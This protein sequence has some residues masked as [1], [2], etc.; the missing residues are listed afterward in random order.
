MLLPSGSP[1]GSGA[2]L[3]HSICRERH[4]GITVPPCCVF[5]LVLL[6]GYTGPAT[7]FDPNPSAKNTIRDDLLASRHDAQL[8]LVF[9][10]AAFFVLFCHFRAFVPSVRRNVQPH[11]Q[12]SSLSGVPAEATAGLSQNGF[13]RASKV[14]SPSS[15]VLSEL[16]SAS[17]STCATLPP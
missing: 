12:T 9:P 8:F 5:C 15:S 3:S 4:R 14:F 17:S 2:P 7:P 10:H 6:L 1:L 11:K 16:R 13:S